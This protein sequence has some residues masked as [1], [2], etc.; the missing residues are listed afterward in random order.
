[1][2]GA[3]RPQADESSEEAR[4]RAGVADIQSGLAHG[5]LPAAT[6][7]GDG[8]RRLVGLDRETELPQR[9]DHDVRVAAE[10]CAVQGRR[11]L[12]Q[13]GEDERAVG[14]ALG[15]GHGD[16]AAH[17]FGEGWDREGGRE[18]IHCSGGL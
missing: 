1:M 10:Q 8:Q 7:H 11:A 6:G 4:G 5:N 3:V 17:R 18:G 2:I 16:A 9:R 14:D 13:R 15:A 12:A